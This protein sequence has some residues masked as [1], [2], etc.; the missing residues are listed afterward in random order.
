MC[1]C[2]KTPADYERMVDG[3]VAECARQNIRYVEAHFTPYNHELLRLRR[4]PRP[5]DGDAA[6]AGRGSRGRAW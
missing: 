5:G 3:F 4:A 1:A 2:L 6:A